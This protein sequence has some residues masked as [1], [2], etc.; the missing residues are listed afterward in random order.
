MQNTKTNRIHALNYFR[1]FA[2]ILVVIDH[3]FLAAGFDGSITWIKQTVN[4]RQMDN[5][6]FFTPLYESIKQLSFHK[7]YIE[8]KHIMPVPSLAVLM[9]FFNQWFCDS[10]LPRKQIY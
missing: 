7:S 1:G 8:L 9:F 2:A 5:T 6:N 4:C 10:I 3:L